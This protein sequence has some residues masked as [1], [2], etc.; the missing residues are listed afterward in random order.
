[1]E[2]LHLNLLDLWRLVDLGLKHYFIENQ[3]LP[4]GRESVGVDDR[5][6]TC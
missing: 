2:I 4:F 5:N 1:M 6:I 3:N